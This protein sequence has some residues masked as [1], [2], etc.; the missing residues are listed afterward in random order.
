MARRN[1]FQHSRSNRE[2]RPPIV[3]NTDVASRPKY[4]PKQFGKPFVVLEDAL[5]HTF[6]FEGGSWVA[7]TRTI[8]ECRAEQCQ[9]K[10][11]AQKVNNMTRYEVSLPL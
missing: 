11:L 8:A 1:S 6:I 9:V 3:V 5:R 7:Y 2:P 4:V 10:Q